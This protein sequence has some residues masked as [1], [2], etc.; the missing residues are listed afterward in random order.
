MRIVIRDEGRGDRGDLHMDSEG[1]S[2]AAISIVRNV[3]RRFD[4]QDFHF[5]ADSTG[6]DVATA[7][8]KSKRFVVQIFILLGTVQPKTELIDT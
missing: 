3:L 6:L 8:D 1:Q 2:P 7:A 5:A 4:L